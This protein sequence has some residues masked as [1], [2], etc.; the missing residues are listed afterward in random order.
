MISVNWAL[1]LIPLGRLHLRPLQGQFHSLGLTNSLHH[2]I[3]QT[4]RSLLTYSFLPWEFPSDLSRRTLQY[5]RMPLHRDGAPT[6]GGF[7]DLGY[8]DSYRPQALYQL[9]GTLHHWVTMLQVMIA[10]GN[11][12]VV[13]S[14]FPL[15]VMS[16]SGSLYV[17]SSSGHSSQCQAHT[18]CLNVIADRLSRPNQPIP[19]ELSPHPKIVARIFETCGAPTVDMCATV[20]NTH[21][22]QFM[23]LVPEPQALTIDALSQDWQGCSMYRFPPF[24]LLNKEIQNLCATQEGE[25]IL[26]EIIHLGRSVIPSACME[27]TA[28]RNKIACMTTGGFTLLTLLQGRDLILLVP[29]LLK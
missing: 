23:S 13:S 5:F 25:I 27:A 16:S 6:H 7:P 11:T 14:T 8:L 19:T 15:P 20:H 9:F 12:T 4:N 28:L 3:S 26:I 18:S 22:P 10:T 17:A 24:P 29:Q 21:L 2:R 1:G